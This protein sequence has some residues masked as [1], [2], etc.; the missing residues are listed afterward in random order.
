MGSVKRRI[1][2]V[3]VATV[4]IAAVPAAAFP[5]SGGTEQ[6]TLQLPG[7][8]NAA[9]STDQI[10][11]KSTDGSI[12]L[13]PLSGGASQTFGHLISDQVLTPEPKWGTPSNPAQQTLGCR[14]DSLIGDAVLRVPTSGQAVD[15]NVTGHDAQSVIGGVCTQ[16]VSRPVPPAKDAANSASA[17]CAQLDVAIDAQLTRSRSGYRAHVTGTVQ[18]ASVRSALAISC[19]RVGTALR[20]TIRPRRRGRTLKQVRVTKLSVALYNP[21]NASVAVRTT[22]TVH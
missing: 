1:A 7:P 12:D 5:P 15:F 17:A 3:A 2:L 4:A 6:E 14:F 21:T 18:R 19:R 20:L 11:A 10:P 22:F 16:V 9:G 13:A 8:G